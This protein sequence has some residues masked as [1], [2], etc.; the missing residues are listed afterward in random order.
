M[1]MV[2]KVYYMLDEEDKKDIK[3]Q[4]IDLELS[5]RQMAKNLNVS[6][7]YLSGVIAGNKHFTP[8][9]KEQFESQG[10]ILNENVDERVCCILDQIQ[11]DK[12]E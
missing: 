1:K 2:T 5:L 12:I 6:P 11:G 3:K 4:M 10:I 7:A 9:L 8:R